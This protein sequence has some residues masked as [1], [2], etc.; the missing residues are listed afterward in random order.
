VLEN[1]RIFMSD[2]LD[3]S[4]NEWGRTHDLS[5]IL[6]R[7]FADIMVDTISYSRWNMQTSKSKCWI[8][9]NLPL[10]TF[11]L[12]AAGHMIL[13]LKLRIDQLLLSRTMK[14]VQRFLALS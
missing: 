2:V 5:E 10:G 14:D 1:V 4:S 8:L 12:H 13:V 7:L 9:D 3:N 6:Q 11:A